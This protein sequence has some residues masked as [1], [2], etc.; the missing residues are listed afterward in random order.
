M[1]S[2]PCSCG[3]PRFKVFR[4]SDY[5]IPMDDPY[6]EL[7]DDELMTLHAESIDEIEALGRTDDQDLL[8]AYEARQEVILDALRSRGLLPI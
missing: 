4:M 3:Y 5:A 7:T 8:D 1:T 6:A 2:M